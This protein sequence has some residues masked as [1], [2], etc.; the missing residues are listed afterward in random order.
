MP[1]GRKKPSTSLPDTFWQ[2]GHDSFRELAFT[3][4][5]KEM[6]HRACNCDPTPLCDSVADKL[7]NRLET[8]RLAQWRIA[9]R[10]L[11]AGM[12][13]CASESKQFVEVEDEDA[14]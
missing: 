2:L 12:L 6:D 11:L 10:E 3:F 4:L 8:V 7:V 5:E 1:K 9:A 13:V 14:S